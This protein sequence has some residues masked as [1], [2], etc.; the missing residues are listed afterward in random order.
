MLLVYMFTYLD[1]YRHRLLHILPV[2]YMHMQGLLFLHH[3]THILIT[4]LSS[5][6]VKVK[7]PDSLQEEINKELEKI[8]LSKTLQT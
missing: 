5:S 3:I 8:Y 2:P 6:Q 1:H 4:G 7:L